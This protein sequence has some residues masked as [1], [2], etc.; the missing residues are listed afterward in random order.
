M[1]FVSE[2]L[3]KENANDVRH[4]KTPDR[5]SARQSHPK[6]AQSHAERRVGPG[7]AGSDEGDN[8]ENEDPE[9]DENKEE[10]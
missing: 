1:P 8:F 3:L 5:V 6:H 7:G 2:G 4:C 10:T 9:E